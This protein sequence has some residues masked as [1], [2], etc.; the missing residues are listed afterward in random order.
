MKQTIRTNRHKCLRRNRTHMISKTNFHYKVV[1]SI[2]LKTSLEFLLIKWTSPW[3]SIPILVHIAYPIYVSVREKIVNSKLNEDVKKFNFIHNFKHVCD[4]RLQAFHIFLDI[5]KKGNIWKT[6][7]RKVNFT[8]STTRWS[9]IK[10]FNTLILLYLR[11]E[12]RKITWNI[13]GM[14]HEVVF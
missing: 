8:K 9:L 5:V 3:R 13:Y 7:R 12:I 2:H 4:E 14:L 10:Y 6:N 1:H 11:F